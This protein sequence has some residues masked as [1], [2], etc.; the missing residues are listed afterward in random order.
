MRRYIPLSCLYTK[1]D[2]T[3]SS[4]PAQPSPK[5]TGDRGKQVAWLGPKIKQIIIK[6]VELLAIA[7]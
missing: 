7:A 3:V 1:D 6:I 4:W 5:K 2:A